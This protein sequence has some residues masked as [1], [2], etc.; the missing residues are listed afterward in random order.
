MLPL[1][2]ILDVEILEAQST[3]AS[4]VAFFSL[5]N[6]RQQCR[7]FGLVTGNLYKTSLIAMLK[8]LP[9]QPVVYEGF[10]VEDLVKFTLDR[11]LELTKSAEC[12]L[13]EYESA[14]ATFIQARTKSEER[15]PKVKPKTQANNAAPAH[16]NNVSASTTVTLRRSSRLAAQAH[17]AFNRPSSAKPVKSSA[18]RKVI[19]KSKAIPLKKAQVSLRAADS[20]CKKS[21]VQHLEAADRELQFDFLGLPAE[22]RDMPA[23]AKT[24][25]LL[26][27]EALAVYYG[28]NRFSV[29]VEKYVRRSHMKQNAW[30]Q[31]LQPCHLASVRS[32]SFTY[33]GANSVLN[34]DFDIRGQKFSIV[35]M[36]WT[37]SYHAAQTLKAYL[38]KPGVPTVAY[39]CLIYHV[40]ATRMGSTLQAQFPYSQVSSAFLAAFNASVNKRVGQATKPTAADEPT[41]R[42]KEWTLLSDEWQARKGF[43]ASSIKRVAAMLAE[44]MTDVK[45]LWVGEFQD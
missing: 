42:S 24:C 40:R 8:K 13:T 34:I 7:V 44:N 41:T 2:T 38:A 16:R 25:Q 12:H 3:I 4:R 39:N 36:S 10:D 33:P 5:K 31:S 17:H 18:A 19:H 32:F 29:A 37:S 30:F 28:V 6:L 26:R 23:I 35:R 27:H 14:R 21:L 20:I 1:I 9:T 15:R 11:H 22:L 45:N 43:S